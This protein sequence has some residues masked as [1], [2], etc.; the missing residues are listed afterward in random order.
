MVDTTVVAREKPNS[1][2]PYLACADQEMIQIRAD[3]AFT[4]SYVSSDTIDISHAKTILILAD[5]DGTGITGSQFAI[6]IVNP[7]AALMTCRVKANTTSGSLALY[8][9]RGNGNGSFPMVNGS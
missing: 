3:A 5:L 1:P 9:L 8:V 4:A 6:P 7:G 2:E